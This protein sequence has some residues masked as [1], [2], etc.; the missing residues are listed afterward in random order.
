[1]GKSSGLGFFTVV[2]NDGMLV[3]QQGF[4]LLEMILVLFLI[5]LMASATLFLTENVEDQ[6]KY[7]E[8]KRRMELIR[9]AIVGD[10]TRT[11]NN[12]P[13]LSGFYMDMGRLPLCLAELLELGPEVSPAT[14]PVT[15]ESPCDSNVSISLWT[16]DG[17]SDVGA[18]WRGPY[19]QTLPEN[20]GDIRFRDGY[21]NS[22]A[23]DDLNSGWK[24]FT[25][26]FDG[27]LSIES[28]RLNDSDTDIGD[29]ALVTEDDYLI[30]LGQSWQD[31]EIEF[32]FPNEDFTFGKNDLRL[33]LNYPING[34]I[35]DWSDATIDTDVEKDISTY[36]SFGFPAFGISYTESTNVYQFTFETNSTLEISPAATLSGSDLT[37]VGNTTI[38]YS[39]LDG[40][41]SV[42][43][44]GSICDTDTCTISDI[45]ANDASNGSVSSLTFSSTGETDQLNANWV[46]VD[47]V[48]ESLAKPIIKV[49]TG[50]SISGTTLTLPNL[51][52]ITL[53]SGSS[54]NV[55]DETVVL[56]DSAITVSDDYVKVGNIVT[57]SSSGDYFW[58]PDGTDEVST[59]ELNVPS[60]LTVPMGEATLS[61]VCND[62]GLLFSSFDDTFGTCDST[63]S[64]ATPYA[65]KFYPRAS[66][67]SLPVPL[68]W[69]IQ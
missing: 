39:N 29:L 31:V 33:R 47:F 35:V 8:T 4:T 42:M 1:L 57:I 59:T 63:G 61:V 15:Y 24:T 22:D 13:E 44:F 40:S 45:P 19:L 53:P 14:T 20:N 38:I 34:E 18:G 23:D 37:V 25:P 56:G 10:R 32:I 69:E 36:L 48:A 11:I 43:Y 6:A 64:L 7:D 55:I 2:R 28:E 58:V 26:N 3:K 16:L 66:T 62:T 60:R 27:S 68:T 41:S 65:V 5:G 51:E 52:T 9:A 67:P 30:T 17:N 49:P 12:E 54:D 46:D 21:R 50:S